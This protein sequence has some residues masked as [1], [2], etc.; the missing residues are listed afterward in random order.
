VENAFSDICAE[1]GL[2]HWALLYEK[3]AFLNYVSGQLK[4]NAPDIGTLS[5]YNAIISILDSMDFPPG[6][7]PE[8]SAAFEVSNFFVKTRLALVARA[9]RVAVNSPVMLVKFMSEDFLFSQRLRE[10]F[11]YT[12]SLDDLVV[13]VTK[14]PQSMSLLFEIN[15]FLS[16]FSKLGPE[17]GLKNAVELLSRNQKDSLGLRLFEYFLARN[18]MYPDVLKELLKDE[19]LRTIFVDDLLIQQT[20]RWNILGPTFEALDTL[21]GYAVLQSF[22]NKETFLSPALRERAIEARDKILKS[23]EAPQF[24]SSVS[25]TKIRLKL[26][27]EKC[28]R[29]FEKLP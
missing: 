17:G 27:W 1:V 8:S 13:R 20:R 16:L 29:F 3:I 26:F 24:R 10:E 7:D 2:K 5:D 22:L 4:L 19:N 12:K 6:S 14:N 28:R 23:H 21:D 25:I 11:D 9:F 18:D 15:G